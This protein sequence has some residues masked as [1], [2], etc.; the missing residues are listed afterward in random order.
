M[1][2]FPSIQFTIKDDKD[3]EKQYLKGGTREFEASYLK[4]FIVLEL[5]V[6][7]LCG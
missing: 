5:K 1:S 7:W 2:E 6:G 3:E 4:S